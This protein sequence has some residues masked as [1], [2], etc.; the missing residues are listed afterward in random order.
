MKFKWSARLTIAV[1][2]IL[3]I[4]VSLIIRIFL[5]YSSIFTSLGIKFAANDAYSHMRIVDSL[6]HHFPHATQFDPYLTYPGG[7]GLNTTFFE[8]L[9]AIITLIVGFGSP[10][11]H[12]IDVMGVLYPCILGA[13]TIIPV[14]FI[15]KALFNRW[16]G[17]LA[18]GLTAVFP[19][20]FLGRSILGYT[21]NHV[22]ET[23]FSTTAVMFL[24]FAI[25]SARQN[26]LTFKSI[27]QHEWKVILKPI[28]FSL[29]AGLF[30]GVYLDTWLG[31]PLFVF[32]ITL[33]YLFQF[34]VDHF[35]HR[36][37]EHLGI[38]G[39]L[40]FLVALVMF[41]PF[42]NYHEMSVAMVVAVLI[43]P[44]LAVVSTLIS[45]WRLKTSYYPLI[46]V[47]G[48]V[49]F[50]LIFHAVSPGIFNGMVNKFDSVFLPGGSTATTTQ[51][52]QH[53]L[54]PIG[55]F[56]TVYAWGNFTT[57]FFLFPSWPIPGFAFISFVILIVLF[58]RKRN[59]DKIWMLL[60]IWT[61]VILIASLIQ[62]RFCY[63][64]IVN[65]ALLSAYLAW[66]TIR[67]FSARRQEIKPGEDDTKIYRQARNVGI[68]GWI[69][70][71]L[72]LVFIH[73]PMYLFIPIWVAWFASTLFGCW[74][75]ARMKGKSDSW[76]LW[77]I[78][79]PVGLII[80]SAL[81]L[82]QWAQALWGILSPLGF[83]PLA[84]DK[85][86]PVKA[87]KKI[88][89]QEKLRL[90]IP[91]ISV[92]VLIVIVF[93]TFFWTNVNGAVATASQAP[94]APSDAWQAALLWM[95]ANTRNPWATPMLTINITVNRQP[96][97]VLNTLTQFTA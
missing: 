61:L 68:L 48:A 42:S 78:I 11:Q 89:I 83:L 93:S 29:L 30:L 4:A 86:K 51:E 84:A 65:M 77:G 55:S 73:S 69:V 39:F 31:A 90:P 41:L 10:S 95:K 59:D 67:F 87:K 80:F 21:D 23:L 25:Q 6:V 47:G 49:V 57:S 13:L 38:V 46:L 12:L 92:A 44:A 19:G 37:T 2:I 74:G 72:A 64:L 9:L 58:I 56:T 62:R 3:F 45:H 97:R 85:S 17:V 88:K 53:L 60:F 20:E 5:P 32:I 33:Y 71:L 75:W 81:K 27:L 91:A 35:R 18:A 14:Y 16:A 94:Y 96:A 22:A 63:Y 43:P 1:L 79:A 34:I 36:S 40:S 7:G 50:A 24:I 15:G 8:Q 26:Q 82:P 54:S 70:I 66:E 28:I 76:A 52:M